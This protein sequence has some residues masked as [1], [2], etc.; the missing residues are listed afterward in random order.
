MG[1]LERKP[2]N[3]GTVIQINGVSIQIIEHIGAGS[4][5]MAYHGRIMENNQVVPGALV[6]VKEFYP[7][8]NNSVF[9]IEREGDGRLKVSR[10]TEKSSEYRNRKRQFDA[11]YRMQKTLANSKAMEIMVKPYLY[12]SYGDSVYLVSDIHMGSSLNQVRF[13]TLEERLAC[14]IRVIE[15][16]GVLHDTGYMLTDFKP[17]NILWTE[18]PRSVKLIDADSIFYLPCMDERDGRDVTEN[19]EM[20][21]IK[22]DEVLYINPKYSSPQILLLK[23]M[24][25]SGSC[26]LTDKKNIYMRPQANVYSMG[27]F[28]FELL[29]GRIP[30][31]IDCKFPRELL[32]ELEKLYTEYRLDETMAASLLEILQ[33]SMNERAG[34]RYENGYAMMDA[35]NLCIEKITS[36]KYM[37]KKTLAKANYTYLSYNLLEQYPLYDYSR[38]EGDVKILDAAVI[39][40]HPLRAH[41]IKAIISSGQML[42]SVL[43]VRIIAEDAEKFWNYFISDECNPELRRTVKWNINGCPFDNEDEIKAAEIVNKPLAIVHLYT[44]DSV[45]NVRSILK[46][47]KTA[48]A[49]CLYEQ[50]ERNR[51]AAG[52][53][54]KLQPKKKTCIGYLDNE[55]GDEPDSTGKVNIYPIRT[56]RTSE[57]YD[58]S[59]YKSRIYN[60]GLSIHEYYYRGGK[61]RA[62]SEEIKKDYVKDIYNME[63]S[64]RSALHANYKLASVG[65][66]PESPDAPYKFYDKV[67]S[68]SSE[69]AKLHFDN[70]LAL[71]HRSWTAFL[72]LS[73]A[74]AV[75]TVQE[76]EAYAFDGDN[77]WKERSN[78]RHMKH[79]CLKASGAGRNLTVNDWKYRKNLP[80][81]RWEELDALDRRCLEIYSVVK[82][83]ALKRRALIDRRLDEIEQYLYEANNEAVNGAYHMLWNAKEKCYEQES[84]GDTLWRHALAELKEICVITG[85]LQENFRRDL[86]KLEHLMKPALWAVRY[87]DF[88]DADA[89]VLRVIPV[90]LIQNRKIQ[91]TAGLTAAAEK[92]PGTINS[93]TVVKPLAVSIWQ[94]VYSSI[95]INPDLLV[96][97]PFNGEDENEVEAYYTR[98]LEEC[99]SDTKVWVRS[100]QQLREY[101]GKEGHIFIDDTGVTPYQARMVAGS[102]YMRQAHTFEVIERRLQ[103]TSGG[104][105]VALFNR[106]VNLTVKET[107]MLHGATIISE[108]MPDYIAGLA[109][110]QYKTLWNLY[111]ELKDGRKWKIFINALKELEEKKTQKI[112]LGSKSAAKTYESDYVDEAALK[113]T[114]AVKVLDELTNQNILAKCTMPQRKAYGK[115][116][117]STEY[118]EAASV[119]CKM[120]DEIIKEPFRHSYKLERSGTMLCLKDSSLYVYGQILHEKDKELSGVDLWRDEVL[121]SA[122]GLLNQLNKDCVIQNAHVIQDK[123]AGTST[124]SFRYASEAVKEVL[125]KE[126][127]ILEAMMFLE[128]KQRAIFDDIRVNVEFMWP[129]DKTKNELDIVGTKN[130]KTYFISAKM[131]APDKMHAYEID[132][133]CQRFA[134]EGQAILV[135]SHYTT[136]KNERTG[137]DF[138]K[139]PCALENRIRDMKTVSYIGKDGVDVL[140]EEGKRRVVIASS[141]AEI[142]EGA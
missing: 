132:D 35:L 133:L 141:I 64:Q 58:E 104:S 68:S 96:L 101:G 91:N 125:R 37:P 26:D 98:L 120:I 115:V 28:M 41:L 52:S 36:R 14:A 44:D 118:P 86:E 10:L 71:E 38:K 114:R 9:D 138:D 69:E 63:S 43:N 55:K 12:G 85:L 121:Q 1:I 27:I 42:N 15:M 76:M 90:I 82:E 33:K 34:R 84:C 66:A 129:G 87:H 117:F 122:V 46:K 97:V 16:F 116:T 112:D 22:E 78:P 2:I 94:N 105:T 99:K 50:E 73:G 135:S 40:T 59:F 106:P 142:V 51:E 108:K 19:E 130:S 20:G 126:G 31:T 110:A 39:G 29:F 124:V 111:R 62:T 21:D 23:R 128:C 67:L 107:L 81:A 13:E 140:G 49:V 102:P 131:Q 11:G 56:N 113:Q 109:I 139:R 3:T 77:D 95:V 25:E 48:Y 47:D 127:S 137:L 72:V 134:I 53:L 54:S 17:E 83:I 8:S 32:I 80:K 30:N 75:D 70:L 61:P 45:V 89:D 100:V 5:C 7:F 18:H 103:P 123:N 74:R 88:K 93:I 60:M 24:I 92:S 6:I 79:P 57:M 65:I 136:G 119:I 4:T